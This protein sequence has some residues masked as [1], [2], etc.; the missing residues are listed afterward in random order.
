MP[1]TSKSPQD[2]G[3]VSGFDSRAE[4]SSSRA[5]DS[6]LV[7]LP[8]W[9]AGVSAAT[10]IGSLLAGQGR[11]AAGLALGCGVALV[12]YWWLH[13]GIRAAFDSGSARAPLGVFVRLALRYPV[14]IGAVLLFDRTGWLPARAVMAGLFA[15]V[16]G[17][18]IECAVLAAQSLRG[19]RGKAF[20]TE[21]TE[22][23]ETH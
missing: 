1:E 13:R 4:S 7:R 16:A 21:V 20:T 6:M 17:V 2:S 12:G 22:A 19:R 5:I 23:T 14:A 3:P 9:I 8:R 10:V 18:L 11:F 15:P